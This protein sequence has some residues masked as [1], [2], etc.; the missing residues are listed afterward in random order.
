MIRQAITFL[1]KGKY[2]TSKPWVFET[3]RFFIKSMNSKSQMSNFSFRQ[4]LEQYQSKSVVLLFRTL[5]C[6]P[7]T[8]NVIAKMILVRIKQQFVLFPI[9]SSNAPSYFF[10]YDSFGEQQNRN[11]TKCNK[12]RKKTSCGKTKSIANKKR[13]KMMYFG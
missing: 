6:S 8:N 1:L 9:I 2:Q 11:G 12:T 10:L 5:I 13:K 3:Q 4:G 7:F